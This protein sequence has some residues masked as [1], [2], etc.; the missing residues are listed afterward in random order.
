M[1]LQT[2]FS[3]LPNLSLSWLP[4]R[5]GSIP[6]KHTYSVSKPVGKSVEQISERMEAIICVQWGYLFACRYI[7]QTIDKDVTLYNIWM[8]CIS[9]VQSITRIFCEENAQ[10]DELRLHKSVSCAYLT[11][12]IKKEKK[13]TKKNTRIDVRFGEN[14]WSR[15]YMNDNLLLQS[16]SKVLEVREHSLRDKDMSTHTHKKRTETK[17]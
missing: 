13:R 11:F 8:H 15:I 2:R 7:C 3:V 16:T 12:K 5:N 9:N 4:I 6:A 1:N 10:S 14:R 17:P